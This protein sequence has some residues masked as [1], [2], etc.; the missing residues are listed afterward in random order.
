MLDN[1]PFLL[2]RRQ[3]SEYLSAQG[4]GI[5][6]RTLAK[7]ASLGGGPEFRHFG[8]KVRY[9]RPALLVWAQRRLSPPRTSTSVSRRGP[10]VYSHSSPC[11]L[12]SEGVPHGQPIPAPARGSDRQDVADT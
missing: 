12:Q 7:M 10:S 11:P 4:F 3:A 1:L 5:A 2:D 9:E 8:R 6:P